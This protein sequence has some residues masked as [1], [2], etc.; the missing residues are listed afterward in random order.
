M[1]I[2]QV[3][4]LFDRMAARSPARLV[5]IQLADMARQDAS[6]LRSPR[7]ASEVSAYKIATAR[8]GSAAFNRGHRGR[9]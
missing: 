2:D 4:A 9:T 5:D 7:S 6:V 1:E 8:L 3:L